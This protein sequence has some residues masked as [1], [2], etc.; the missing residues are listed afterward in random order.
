MAWQ[1]SL[2]PLF[3]ILFLS[4]CFQFLASKLPLLKIPT[5][6]AYIFL[7]MILNNSGFLSFSTS[8]LHWLNGIS[9]FGLFY[10]M[11]LS[12]LEVDVKMFDIRS[13][14]G[15]TDTHDGK[16]LVIG[17]MMFVSTAFLS[18]LIARIVQQMDPHVQAWMMMLILSTTSLGII[19]P[20]LKEMKLI[21]SQ[22]GQTLLTAAFLADL[23]TML[24]ISIAADIYQSGWHI[25][26]LY[27]GLLLPFFII[28][29]LMI[30]RIRQTS[31]WDKYITPNPTVKIQAS[32]A[33]L[34]LFGIVTDFVGA[35]SLLGSFLAG[36]LFSCFRLGEHNRLRIQLELIGY[37]FLIPIFFIMVGM[38]FHLRAFLHDSA[39]L[40]WIPFLLLSAYAVKF[41]P[42][43]WFGR[44]FGFR[45]VVAGGVL[46]SSR[47]TLV[48]VA[49][50]IGLHLG[51]VSTTIYEAMIIV[52]I[53]TCTLSP[54]AFVMLQKTFT[55]E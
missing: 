45:N 20:V 55:S 12:G 34:G 28:L 36:I 26:Q 9:H 39:A 30:Q 21:R 4:F 19:L 8:D 15:R 11:F 14:S 44:F 37:S 41:L 23:L 54:I 3:W 35:E 17:C 42:T 6:I 22:Y 47:L 50:S 1:N 7:G 40:S 38:Q 52:A 48:I 18:Y 24:A 33:L 46:L 51:I 49:C 43:L 53:L 31:L 10:L 25:R 29:Y 27:V 16:P 32:L 5:V 13:D 2:V